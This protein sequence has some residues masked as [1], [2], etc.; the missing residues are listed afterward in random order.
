MA[1]LWHGH[2]LSES[3]QVVL[4]RLPMAKLGGCF[5]HRD[6][7]VKLGTEK[8]RKASFDSFTQ[9]TQLTALQWRAFGALITWAHVH[10]LIRSW[11][12]K[13]C[14]IYVIS[15]VRGLLSA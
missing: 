7:D 10:K 1:R 3:V 2:Y 6:C 4:A 8:H 5:G 13:R 11:A 14:I 15:T 12:Q 9:L